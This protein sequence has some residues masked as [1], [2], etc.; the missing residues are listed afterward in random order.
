MVQG[1]GIEPD[2]RVFQ[3]LVITKP[4]HLAYFGTSGQTRTATSIFTVSHA[5]PTT[6][7]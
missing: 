7:H 1:P 3:T 5:D 4:T 2:S 6:L